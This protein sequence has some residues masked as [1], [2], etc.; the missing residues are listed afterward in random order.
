LNL[1]KEQVE[2]SDSKIKAWNLLHRYT[3]WCFFRNRHNEFKEFFSLLYRLLDTTRFNCGV[4]L[5]T[6]PKLA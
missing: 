2:L 6:L 3:E 5:K 4:C 1:S